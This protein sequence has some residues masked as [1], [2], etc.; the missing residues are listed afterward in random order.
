MTTDAATTAAAAAAASAPAARARGAAATARRRKGLLLRDLL[1]FYLPASV[2]ALVM[3]FPLLWMVSFAVRPM[4]EVFTYPP[5]LWPRVFALRNLAEVWTDPRMQFGLEFWNTLVY[6]TVR[7]FLQ[8]M[9]ASMAAHVLARFEFPGR[10]LV[11]GLILATALIPHEVVLITL[12]LVVKHMPFSGGND[13]LGRGGVGWLDSFKG[14]ILP[15]VVSGYSIFLMRQ[16]MLGIPREL[17]EAARLDGCGEFGLYWRISLPLALPGLTTLGAFSFQ[18][19]WS[20]FMWP[21]IIT[22]TDHIR[23]LQLGLAV[24]RANDGTDWSLLMAGAF[25][26]TLPLVA[27]FLLLQRFITTGLN[28]SVGK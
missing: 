19:A 25:F 20:D 6:A 21:L 3:I 26:S 9:L 10:N 2:I 27:M 23:T 18:F 17:E 5:H 24:L 1:G 13:W 8:L 12:Y 28:L 11:F 15:G 22:S 4:S 7:T 14:L 16:F